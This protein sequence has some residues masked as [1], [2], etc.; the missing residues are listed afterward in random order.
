MEAGMRRSGADA[1]V[2]P[3]PR[4]EV[5]GEVEEP[6]LLEL[7]RGVERRAVLDAA[8]LVADGV[9]DRVALLLGAPVGHREQLVRPI[10]VGRALV[11]V[12]DA[13]EGGHAATGL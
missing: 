7:G 13:T 8:D 2:L 3:L 11:A 5:V 6:D 12:A 9:E 4:L 10:G 1:R